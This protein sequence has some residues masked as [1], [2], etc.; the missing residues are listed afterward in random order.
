MS[1]FA[2]YVPSA[3][4][5]RGDEAA[6]QVLASI[7]RFAPDVA[8]CVV[9]RQVLAPGDVEAGVGLTG[10]HIFQGEIL[11]DQMWERRFAARTGVPGLYLCGAATHPGGS[12]MARNGRNAAGAVLEDLGATTR[13]APAEA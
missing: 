3:T 6:D 7:D 4:S 9:E 8:E 12:V 10:G 11:P 5:A 1:V 2:Q 13:A